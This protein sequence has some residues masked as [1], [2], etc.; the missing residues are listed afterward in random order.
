[1]KANDHHIRTMRGIATGIL[2]TILASLVLFFFD[3]HYNQYPKS[4]QDIKVLES[5]LE[6]QN[7]YLER[8]DARTEKIFEVLIL[9]GDK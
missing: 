7:K 6:A 5:K 2:T 4:N 1:M 3:F 9:K 8:I